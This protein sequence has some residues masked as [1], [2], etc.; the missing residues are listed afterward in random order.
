M[1]R[2]KSMS[3][4]VG[5]VVLLTVLGVYLAVSSLDNSET[6]NGS[7]KSAAVSTTGVETRSSR[8]ENP[9]GEKV[10]TP[11]SEDL[12][13]QYIHAMSHQKVEAEEK[14]SF[15][16][17]TPERIDYLLSQL[18]INKYNYKDRYKQILTNWQNGDFSEAVSD[19]NFI[20]RLKN[21][22]VGIATDLLTSKEEKEYIR[23]QKREKR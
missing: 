19:H 7:N 8:E 4:I 1:L 21:G 10:K 14:W 6:G 20:W 16:E 23:G 18:E 3:V 17:I 5:S 12:I 11:L 22:N 9:F 15:F 2:K 13:Q